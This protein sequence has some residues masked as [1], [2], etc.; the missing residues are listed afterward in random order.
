M[1][2]NGELPQ[3]QP[4]K[5]RFLNAELAFTSETHNFPLGIYCPATSAG[6]VQSRCLAQ[7]RI[8]QRNTGMLGNYIYTGLVYVSLFKNVN[9]KEEIFLRLCL[10]MFL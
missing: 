2:V 10:T 5:Y 6:A 1:D 7:D 3:W 4:R 8:C 9:N